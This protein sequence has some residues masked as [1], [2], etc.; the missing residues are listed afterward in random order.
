MY[1]LRGCYFRMGASIAVAQAC[2]LLNAE[3]ISLSAESDQR[4]LASGL[5]ANF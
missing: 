3:G 2:E 5:I 1:P 4:L